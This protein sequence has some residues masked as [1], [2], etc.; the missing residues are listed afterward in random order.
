MST[1]AMGA[2]D[3]PPRNALEYKELMCPTCGRPLIHDSAA[4]GCFVTM[5]RIMQCPC[6]EDVVGTFYAAQ[7][8][9]EDRS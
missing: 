2:C 9:L 4:W 7:K 5:P 6:G 1:G 3:V 8:N